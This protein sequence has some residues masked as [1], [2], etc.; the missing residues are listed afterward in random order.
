MEFFE[1]RS[2]G[3]CLLENSNIISIAWAYFISESKVE[4]AV[5]TLEKYRGKGVSAYVTSAMI[6][7]SLE[8][9]ISPYWGC[10][11]SNAPSIKLGEKL[12][13]KIKNEYYWIYP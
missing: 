13:F 8:R 10:N 3:Y 6:K 4:I 11:E 12:G 1:K 5:K 9:N 2:F 7:S